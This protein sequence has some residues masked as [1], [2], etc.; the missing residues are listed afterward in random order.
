[1]RPVMSKSELKNSFVTG[2]DAREFEEKM[3]RVEELEQGLNDLRAEIE[4]AEGY[5][6]RALNRAEQLTIEEIGCVLYEAQQ[7]VVGDDEDDPAERK[8]IFPA[9]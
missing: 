2:A 9:V 3:E 5:E 1:M 7:L 6:L 4:D 8:S